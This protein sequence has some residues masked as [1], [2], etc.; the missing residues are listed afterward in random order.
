MRLNVSH[1]ARGIP[2]TSQ[3]GNTQRRKTLFGEIGLPDQVENTIR[4]ITG[5]ELSELE[6]A[7]GEE[8]Q[9]AELPA[10]DERTADA[11]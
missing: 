3:A 1:V 6:L 4:P 7:A 2:S 8:G 11:A 9:L 5:T 10:P